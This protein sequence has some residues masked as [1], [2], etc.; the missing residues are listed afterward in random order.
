MSGT[1]KNTGS[2]PRGARPDAVDG[3]WV[4]LI[5]NVR[6]MRATYQVRLLAYMAAQSGRNLWIDLPADCVIHESLAQF[7]QRNPGLI[8]V[9]QG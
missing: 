9:R 2:Q 6:I 7:I 1:N 5:K 4:Y 8:H 3:S